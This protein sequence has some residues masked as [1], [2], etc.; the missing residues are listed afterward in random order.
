MPKLRRGFS[1]RH[2]VRINIGTRRPIDGGLMTA[3]IPAGYTD[4][5]ISKE[6]RAARAAMMA[7]HG[8]AILQARKELE[9]HLNVNRK[10]GGCPKSP[11]KLK[12]KAEMKPK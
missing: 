10:H 1:N 7:D 8:P 11:L 12:Q 3:P 2:G 4:E 9:A 6:M 5:M